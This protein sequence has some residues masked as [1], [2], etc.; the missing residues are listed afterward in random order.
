ML[1]RCSRPTVYARIARG[2]LPSVRLSPSGPLLVPVGELKKRLYEK[3]N[4]RPI[5]RASIADLASSGPFTSLP[6][7]GEN[8]RKSEA[9]PVFCRFGLLGGD[10]R[11]GFACVL[12]VM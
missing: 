6:R 1:L 2:E 8:G 11:L 4:P 9:S 7:T 10:A 12:P 5:D 3:E